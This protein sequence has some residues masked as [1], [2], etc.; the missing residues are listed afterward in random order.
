MAEFEG[1]VYK[2]VIN[3][4]VSLTVGESPL[5]EGEQPVCPPPKLIKVN[6][7][8]VSGSL[9]FGPGYSLDSISVTFARINGLSVD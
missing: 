9:D 6:G 8:P 5:M 4:V 2:I 3:L 7:K 1:K